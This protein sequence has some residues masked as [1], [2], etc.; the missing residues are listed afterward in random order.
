MSSRE[1]GLIR[2]AAKRES[3]VGEF[4]PLDGFPDLGGQLHLRAVWP[5]PAD[6]RHLA[7]DEDG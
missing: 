4:A 3:S 1:A 2:T 6:V 5:R 7:F